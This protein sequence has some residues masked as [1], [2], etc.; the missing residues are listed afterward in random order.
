MVKARQQWL[1]TIQQAL[2][3]VGLMHLI[4]LR[5]GPIKGDQRRVEE[6]L[7]WDKRNGTFA[8]VFRIGALPEMPIRRLVAAGFG[9]L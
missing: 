1:N 2:S 9:I 3:L 5:T 7:E 4:R 8:D 6:Q